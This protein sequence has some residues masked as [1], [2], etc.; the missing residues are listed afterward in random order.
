MYVN[1]SQQGLTGGLFKG[2]RS[3]QGAGMTAGG[4]LE[5][6]GEV[7]KMFKIADASEEV[8]QFRVSKDAQIAVVV[9]G[10]D[11]VHVYRLFDQKTGEFLGDRKAMAPVNKFKIRDPEYSKVIDL[12]I[13]KKPQPDNS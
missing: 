4:T 10:N 11:D 7:P 13:H 6:R 1:A 12:H 2:G 5:S 8:K 9:M 3:L